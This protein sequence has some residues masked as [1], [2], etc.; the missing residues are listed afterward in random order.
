MW[1]ASGE[2]GRRLISSLR[3]HS[4][5]APPCWNTSADLWHLAATTTLADTVPSTVLLT[6][7]A[8]LEAAARGEGL[9]A[10]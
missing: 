4:P 10:Q 8:N 5:R 6:F 2:A 1:R 9:A 3:S 7:D